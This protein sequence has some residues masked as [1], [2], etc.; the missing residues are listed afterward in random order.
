MRAHFISQR[1]TARGRR[2]SIRV[3]MFGE[4]SE[5]GIVAGMPERTRSVCTW[6]YMQL[7]LD[8]ALAWVR[9]REGVIRS[10]GTEGDVLRPNTE[11]DSI[12]P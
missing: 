12:Y 11:P 8:W 6:S 5:I 7:G 4:R 3:A 9:R 10:Q 1:G 2:V